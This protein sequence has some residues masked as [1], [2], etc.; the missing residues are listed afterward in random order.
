MIC[1]QL[2]NW[3]WSCVSLYGDNCRLDGARQHTKTRI[4]CIRPKGRT[5]CI[6]HRSQHTCL[7]IY[8]YWPKVISY[9]VVVG[10]NIVQ[11]TKTISIQQFL[12]CEFFLQNDGGHFGC[13]KIT[14]DRIS[15]HF[16]SIHN[17]F[18]NVNYRIRP[19]IFGWAMRVKFEERILNPSKVIALTK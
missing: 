19:V 4:V 11:I 8:I 9:Q 3:T 6:F 15:G 18:D 2:E 16:R 10:P 12:F 13:P 7:Y 14:F 5:Q 17:F 1:D